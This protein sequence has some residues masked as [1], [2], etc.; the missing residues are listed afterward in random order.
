MFE[1]S[2]GP[3]SRSPFKKND[4]I[5][6]YKEIREILQKGIK[7]RCSY[8][9]LYY[10][11]SEK[12]RLGIVIKRQKN[13][14]SRNRIKRKIREIFRRTGKIKNYDI[15]VKIDR[16]IEKKNIK[17]MEEKINEYFPE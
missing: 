12:K 16:V 11:K 1:K 5:K 2:G 14:V 17:K 10:R 15:I 3:V 9:F 6:N 13:A 7:K 4:R 8:F